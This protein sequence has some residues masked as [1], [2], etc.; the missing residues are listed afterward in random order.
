[1]AEDRRRDRAL[2]RA[3][4]AYLRRQLGSRGRVAV[5]SRHRLRLPRRP[6]VLII[7]GSLAPRLRRALDAGAARRLQFSGVANA[8]AAPRAGLAVEVWDP[9]DRRSV[10]DPPSSF[11]VAAIVTTF[12]ETEIIDQLLDRLLADGIRVQV[13]DNWSTDGTFE[14]VSD[15]ATRESVSVE[16][17]PQSGPNRYFDLAGLLAR[18][19]EVA[20]ASVADWVLHHDADEIHESPWDG[21]SLRNGLWAVDRFGFNAVDHFAMDFRPVDNRW[22]PGV[23]LAT[24]FECFELPPY[25]SYFTLVKGWK[26]QPTK[27]DIA[28][29]GGHEALFHDRRVFPYK[30]LIR[31]YPIRSQS[32]GERKILG[33]RKDRFDPA[34]RE[35][36]WHTHYDRFVEGSSFLWDPVALHRFD[37][38]DE[39]LFIQRLSSAGLPGNPR[40]KESLT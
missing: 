30:F 19:E 27:V 17:W 20:H 32:H 18:V 10:G 40:P 13:I 31:H 6:D 7:S 26:P 5:V 29:T 12:N 28:G 16:R 36:G 9:W 38:L 21:V 14:R 24:S 37:Q 25:S 35:K 4:A 22:E 2:V 34:E 39:R 8:D 23:D 11:T 15:R 3:F 33:E 1:M